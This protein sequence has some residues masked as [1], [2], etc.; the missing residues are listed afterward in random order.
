MKITLRYFPVVGR[1]QP[2]RHALSDAQLDFHDLQVALSDWPGHKEDPGFAGIFS[3]LPTLS[4]GEDTI[5]ETLAISSFLARRLGHYQGL[6]DA[7]I[8]HLE[9]VCS[10]CYTEV[11]LRLGELIWA[12]LIYPGANLAVAL[13]MLLGRMQDKMRRL[14]ALTPEAGWFGRSAPTL[15]DFFAAES[16]ECLGYLLGDPESLGPTLPRLVSLSRRI[17]E[18]PALAAA[19]QAR[20]AQFT[21]RGDEADALNRLRALIR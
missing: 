10:N 6:G 2:L 4:W 21:A 11:M 19:F 12:D 5:C 15:A 8:A 7:Q 17:R 1:A 13:P 18:R 3:A 9:A 16:V 14:E 20:P